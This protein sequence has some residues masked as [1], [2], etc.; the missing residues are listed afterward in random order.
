MTKVS[1]CTI[2]YNRDSYLNLIEKTIINQIYPL[3]L[4]EWIVIDDSDTNNNHEFKSKDILEIKYKRLKERTSIGKKRNIG[5]EMASGEIILNMDDD[6]FYPKT[7]IKHAVEKLE[8]SRC[9]I[10]GCNTIPIYFLNE[11]ELWSSTIQNYWHS[12]ASTFAYKRRLLEITSF[13]NN[14]WEG[15]EKYFLKNYSIELE[16]L[17][18]SETIIQIAH[19]SNTVAKEQIKLFPSIFGAKQIFLNKEQK[20]SLK[21]SLYIYKQINTISKSNQISINEK[22]KLILNPKLNGWS[23]IN[24][25]DFCAITLDEDVDR[26][27]DLKNHLNILGI[28]HIYSDGISPKDLKN[29][30]YD[31]DILSSN[32]KEVL[33]CLLAHFFALKNILE[34]SDKKFFLIMEDDVRFF[35]KPKHLKEVLLLKDH[36]DIIQLGTCN[37]EAQLELDIF[38]ESGQIISRWTSERFGAHAYLISREYAKKIL[39]K[40][41]TNDGSIDLKNAYG[42]LVADRLLFQSGDAFSMNFPIAMQC[43]KYDSNIGYTNPHMDM[44]KFLEN[45]LTSKW[46]KEANHFYF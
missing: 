26:L 46:L 21:K 25:I 42:Y 13:N 15:E 24:N 7:R 29:H 38:Y 19:N 18:P 14:D 40:Y 10:A 16:Q 11:D 33:C 34:K 1:I 20:E 43:H 27:K 4:I 6:D 2:T 36:W 35:P 37:L 5:N 41:F 30:I 23:E 32:K 17:D 12:I 22:R 39:K 44:H 8:S 28:N 31:D 3:D 45:Y 9:L